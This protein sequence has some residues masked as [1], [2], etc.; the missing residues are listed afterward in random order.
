[1]NFLLKIVNNNPVSNINISFKCKFR[2]NPP[3]K[4]RVIHEIEVEFQIKLPDELKSIYRETNGVN[5]FL[6]DMEIGSLIWSTDYL[7]RENKMYRET[8][9]FKDLYMPFDHLLFFADAGNGDNFGYTILNGA[10]QRL[11]IFAWNHE[12]DSRLWVAPNLE[13]FIEWWIEGKIT[14]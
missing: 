13:K 4:E 14:I 6:G 12:D 8:A 11:D 10:I 1:M 2:F 5:E 7:I 3:S 9:D